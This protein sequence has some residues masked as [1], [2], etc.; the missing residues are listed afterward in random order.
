[1]AGL[2]EHKRSF[3]ARWVEMTGAHERV[4]APLRY[5]LGRL[6]ARADRVVRR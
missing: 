5:S 3:G 2:Y 1:M 4:I 6:T